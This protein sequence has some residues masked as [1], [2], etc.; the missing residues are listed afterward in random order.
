MGQSQQQS[1]KGFVMDKIIKTDEEWQTCLTPEQYQV[2]REKGTERAFTGKYYKH[3][4]KGTYICAG[5]DNELFSSETKYDSG[6]GWPAFFDAIDPKK[7][8]TKSDF[9]FGMIRTEITCAKCGS[10]L[11]HVF[12]DGP[13]PTGL[14]YCVNSLSLKFVAK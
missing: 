2:L 1:S 12:E 3:K 6:S 9:S 8:N 13:K 4:A 11:G 5:C 10:H 7:V 14:R